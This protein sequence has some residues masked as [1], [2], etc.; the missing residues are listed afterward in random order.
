[1]ISVMDRYD[2][3][4]GSLDRKSDHYAGKVLQCDDDALSVQCHERR[5]VTVYD[6]AYETDLRDRVSRELI[7]GVV[8][9]VSLGILN[10]LNPSV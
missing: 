4:L 6:V 8:G 3:I 10:L 9:Y 2:H 7:A 1:V 5:P